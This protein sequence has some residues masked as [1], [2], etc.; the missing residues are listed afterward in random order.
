M[1]Y[2]WQHHIPI[3]KSDGANMGP[4]L[5][6]QGPG[7]PR[8][9]PINLAIRDGTYR[10]SWTIQLKHKFETKQEIMNNSSI[11]SNTPS[12]TTVT[13]GVYMLLRKRFPSPAP[14]AR[15]M[16]PMWGP[17]GADRTQVGPM[18]TPWT[19]LSGCMIN[20]IKRIPLNRIT[21]NKEP[22][23]VHILRNVM[24]RQVTFSVKMTL[25]YVWHQFTILF[26]A[27]YSQLDSLA[28][29]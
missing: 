8:I 15:F 19:L 3:S 25:F 20:E 4:T 18:L 16:G 7:G 1:G 21:I 12:L 29:T 26:T 17:Y 9:S 28:Q 10:V 24:Y 11:S 2:S 13:I 6:R 14:I 27:V 23:A 5:D 22:Y